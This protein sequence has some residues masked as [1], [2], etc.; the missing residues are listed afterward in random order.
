MN[1][2]KDFSKLKYIITDVDIIGILIALSN[3]DIEYVIDFFENLE[4]IKEEK[5]TYTLEQLLANTNI[6]KS[7][8]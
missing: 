4:P 3:D 8:Q 2:P 1:R 5:I 6:V 7:N